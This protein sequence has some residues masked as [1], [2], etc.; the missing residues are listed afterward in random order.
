MPV[1]NLFGT[2]GIRGLIGKE[3]DVKFSYKLGLALGKYIAGGRAL[4]ARDPRPGAKE[5]TQALI[6]G[7][8]QAGLKV[9]DCGILATPELTWYQVKRGCDLG[10]CVTGS[11]LPWNMIG[12]IPTSTEGAGITSEVGQ[13]ITEIFYGL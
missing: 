10:V 5:L 8:G 2:S 11:H 12:I 4:V 3:I 13:R 7:L 1:R 9:T 6:K